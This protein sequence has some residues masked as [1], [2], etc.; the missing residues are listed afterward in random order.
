VQLLLEKG[1]DIAT[2]DSDGKTA[3]DWADAGGH[4][5]VVQLLLENRA[6]VAAEDVGGQDAVVQLLPSNS[7][8]TIA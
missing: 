1:A 2:K 3:L 6:D 7:S 5:A 8:S 4:E